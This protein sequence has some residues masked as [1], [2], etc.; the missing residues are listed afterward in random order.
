MKS[1]VMMGLIISLNCWTV[2]SADKDINKNIVCK[3]ELESVEIL[4]FEPLYIAVSLVN[5]T[6]V[7]QKVTMSMVC[8]SQ[9]SS[10]GKKWEYYYPMGMV[11]Y[12]PPAPK[13][14]E[15]KPKEI[16]TY[17]FSYDYNQY[18]GKHIFN[19]PGTYYVKASIGRYQSPQVTVKVKEPTGEDVKAYEYLK[20]AEKNKI[21][22]AGYFTDKKGI[23]P[24][25]FTGKVDLSRIDTGWAEI[26]TG[27]EKLSKDFSTSI[28]SEY[29]RLG[30]G[31]MWLNGVDKKVDL[32]KSSEIFTKLSEDSKTPIKVRAKYYLGRCVD[33]REAWREIQRNPKWKPELDEDSVWDT[34][35]RSEEAV[36]HYQESLKMSPDPYFK[37]LINDL[38]KDE[39]K[40]REQIKRTKELLS[41]KEAL[42][43]SRDFLETEKAATRLIELVGKE[44][45]LLILDVLIKMEAKDDTVKE[46]LKAVKAKLEK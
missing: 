45:A 36:K 14:I 37:C 44:N 21:L 32:D 23:L 15:F 35:E 39:T 7:V 34:K 43:T 2:F 8:G 27:L 12:A 41:L 26:L 6:D 4:P 3:A 17:C 5:Q 24:G 18:D 42:I 40:K 10:D 38:L 30:I 28:Y 13:L 20:E 46:L 29:A 31:L 9:F 22:L 11:M 25:L 19:Q 1:I 16:E 33:K